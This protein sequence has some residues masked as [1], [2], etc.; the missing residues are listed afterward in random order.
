PAMIKRGYDKALACGATCAGGTLGILI[1]PSIMLVIYGPMAAISVGKLFF[2]AFI[3]GFLLSGLYCTY[4]AIRCFIQKGLAPP[5]PVEDRAVPWAK[6]TWDL[7]VSMLPPLVLILAVLGSIF[8]GI[9]TPTEAASVGS[10]AATI[11]AIAYRRFNFKVLKDTMTETI[12]VTGM[13]LLVGATAF[14]FVGVFMR[15]GGGDIVKEII[16]AAPGGKWGIFAIIMFV[17]FLLGYFID[18]LGILFI[19]V[20]IITPVGDALGFDKLW[21]AMMICV[22]LQTSFLTPP[23]AYAI[24]YLKGAADPELG[25]TT[26]DIIRGVFPFIF[27]ILI[28]L[29]LCIAF[30]Q[31]IL[32]LPGQMI[33]GF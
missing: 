2:A 31:I 26:G 27:L 15:G 1:P 5:V 30:P 12:K 14:A 13:V 24:F 25:V 4:I 8:M 21:F 17:V 32:W 22:N 6:K 3:P 33:T 19:I 10:L 9:A 11:M 7:L 28:G 16:L 29:G 23:F 18:W 20:P